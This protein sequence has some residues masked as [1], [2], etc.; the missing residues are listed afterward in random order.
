MLQCVYTFREMYV[1]QTDFLGITFQ[2]YSLENVASKIIKEGFTG[3]SYGCLYFHVCSGNQYI[4]YLVPILK[5]NVWCL[6][7][8]FFFVYNIY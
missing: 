1:V 3:Y 2:N 8:A 5:K 7:L 4:M 6:G